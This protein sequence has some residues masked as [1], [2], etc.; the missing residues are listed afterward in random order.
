MTSFVD[1]LISHYVLDQGNLVVAHAGM[2]EP[3]Q[4]RSSGRV[5]E[6]ALYGE[7]I[8]E[9]DE[10][11]LPVRYNWAAEYR[12]KAHVVY[13][14]TPAANA[15]WI[16]RTICL[17]TGCVFGGR[18]TAL[19]YPEKELVAVP[20]GRVYYEPA[21]PLYPQPLGDSADGSNGSSGLAKQD[22]MLRIEDVSG[23][24]IIETRLMRN[25]TIREENSIAA[26]EI[27][28]RFAANPQ[29]LIYLPPTMSPTETTR[30]EGYL[31][32]PAEAFE[33]YR[34]RGVTSV[35]CEEKHMGSRA[36]L[37]VCRDQSVPLKRF[38]VSEESFGMC[39]TRTGRARFND[40]DA[41]G[42]IFT[43]YECRLYPR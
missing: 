5:R 2:K 1:S 30:R 18:L 37:I 43:A 25:V 35:V 6:F 32:H 10:Y 33:H 38:G 36:V 29:W 21:K 8:G 3:Y 23:K 9:T 11:G 13:G 40:K 39:C 34:Q 28:S 16:N 42:G 26:L 17:D 22:D 27:M 41:G 4:G 20:A 15:E 12:G 31:E 14:H 24:R 19:R 7:T